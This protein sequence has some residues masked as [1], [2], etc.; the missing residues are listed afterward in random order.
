MIS[1]VPN[2][3]DLLPSFDV[4]FVTLNTRHVTCGPGMEFS[5]RFV[6]CDVA[7]IV[8]NELG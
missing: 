5:Y 8:S 3:I 4:P 1:Y 6:C 7:G 2:Y